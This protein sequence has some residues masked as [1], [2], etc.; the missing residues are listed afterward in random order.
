MKQQQRLDRKLL[1]EHSMSRTITSRRT[2]IRKCDRCSYFSCLGRFEKCAERRHMHDFFTRSVRGS[3]GSGAPMPII[4]THFT[5]TG[6]APKRALCNSICLHVEDDRPHCD[7]G[8]LAESSLAANK[9]TGMAAYPVFETI[10]AFRVSWGKTARAA[11]L[12][13]CSALNSRK[14]RWRCAF[15]SRNDRALFASQCA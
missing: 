12:K 1:R 9:V 3:G 10:V 2:L 11:Q 13:K 14:G 5:Q 4:P 7:K 6:C 8:V 15:W